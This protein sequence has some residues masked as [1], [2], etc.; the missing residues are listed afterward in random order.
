MNSLALAAALTIALCACSRGSTDG[1]STDGQPRPAAPPSAPPQGTLALGEPVTSR[2]VPLA[3][4]AKS[5]S[6]FENQ[7]VATSGRVTAVCQEMGCW[8]EIADESGQAHIKMHG[9]A[10]FVP[11]TAAGHLARVQARVLRGSAEGC[12]E[13]PPPRNVASAVPKVELDATGVELD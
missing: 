6:R 2:L 12:D 3:E 11:K 1:R 7:L 13:S 9:H 4:I 5:P 8:M 10:F